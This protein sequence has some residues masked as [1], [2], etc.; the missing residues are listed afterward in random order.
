MLTGIQAIV[1][2]L[3][4]TLYVN[5]GLAEDIYRTACEYMAGLQGISPEDADILIRDTRKRL[6]ATG[7]IGASLTTA[8]IE[9]GGDIA[10]F[11]RA[12]T[13]SIQPENRLAR[14]EQLADLLG[15]LAERRALYIYTN[16]NRTLTGRILDTLGIPDVFRKIFTIEDFWRP[17]P[18]RSVLDRILNIIS[19]N[20]D[21]CLFIGDRYDIDLRIPA[22]MGCQVYLVS[23]VQDLMALKQGVTHDKTIQ[24]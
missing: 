4:G 16:N 19:M 15:H 13:I 10:G 20:P 21:K 22:E 7:I 8:C 2:D 23:A 9:L 17:K 12:A 1:F 5:E 18:D 14:D 3:D 11:H 24:S 6:S